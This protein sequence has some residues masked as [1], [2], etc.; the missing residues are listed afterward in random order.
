MP[1]TPTPNLNLT[2]PTVAGDP[3]T[4]GNEINNDLAIIDQLGVAGQSTQIANFTATP[5]IQP[6]TF[7]RV[8]TGSGTI[9]ATLLPIL[10]KIVTILK[11]DAGV[12]S[13]VIIGSIMGQA[14]YMLSN[15]FQYVRLQY[16][17]TT[18]DVVGNN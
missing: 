8:T 16:N 12:G 6:E 5:G 10:N 13:V 14:S 17:G 11:V 1:G 15:E 7:F 2:V 3:N 9:T 18:Y 4:W